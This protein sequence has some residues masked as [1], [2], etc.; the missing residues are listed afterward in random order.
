M[1]ITLP[2]LP[3]GLE[4][5]QTEHGRIYYTRAQLKAYGHACATAM[6]IAQAKPHPPQGAAS[7]ADL[8]GLKKMFGMTN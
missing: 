7:D 3:A 6:L 2:A 8:A 4:R 1:T 5:D